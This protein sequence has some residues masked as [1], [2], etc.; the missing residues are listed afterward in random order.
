MQTILSIVNAETEGK[1]ES[2]M[3]RARQMEEIREARQR[4]SEA[5]EQ[6]RKD[7]IENKK[8]EIRQ[9]RKKSKISTKPTEDIAPINP[10]K[11]K[12]VSFG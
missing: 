3:V 4:E 12:K 5:K 11:K 9:N 7:T 2:K 1:I 6:S 8:D 10:R